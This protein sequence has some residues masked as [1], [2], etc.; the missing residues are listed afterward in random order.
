MIIINDIDY[1]HVAKAVANYR[2]GRD[3]IEDTVK[4]VA[5]HLRAG[6]RHTCD[7]LGAGMSARWR[8]EDALFEELVMQVL[9][10]IEI[11]CTEHKHDIKYKMCDEVESKAGK[12]ALDKFEAEKSTIEREATQE[13]LDF[14]D[15]KK[16]RER[17]AMS[18]KP[19]KKGGAK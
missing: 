3:R 13:W 14:H 18:A 8:A 19:H 16:E 12:E 1:R 11:S 10:A 9:V 17:K 15:W 5:D 7:C 2:R 6:Q 4:I